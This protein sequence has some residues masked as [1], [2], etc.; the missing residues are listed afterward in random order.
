MLIGPLREVITQF[1]GFRLTLSKFQ[2]LA[3]LPIFHPV[4]QEAYCLR[5]PPIVIRRHFFKFRGNDLGKRSNM[6]TIT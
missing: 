6:M 4:Y 5:Y 1:M 2:I 3:Y